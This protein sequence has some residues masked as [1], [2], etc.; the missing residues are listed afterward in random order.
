M[1]T[2]G[3]R[4]YLWRFFVFTALL[5][6]LW[7]WAVPY[8]LK[9]DP[10]AFQAARNSG[11]IFGSGAALVTLCLVWRRLRQSITGA[12]PYVMHGFPRGDMCRRTRSLV[13][14]Q[15]V[16]TSPFSSFAVLSVQMGIGLSLGVWMYFLAR[17][18]ARNLSGAPASAT[19]PGLRR[20]MTIS[21]AAVALIVT[22]L[23]AVGLT[24][25]SGVGS[26]NSRSQT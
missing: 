26:T 12:F 10:I 25:R 15:R 16:Q 13:L 14:H 7:G 11:F 23:L 17:R 22:F 19:L 9:L 18:A 21:S 3:I 8:F 1:S 5:P 20:L 2:S 4:P 6:I 24:A